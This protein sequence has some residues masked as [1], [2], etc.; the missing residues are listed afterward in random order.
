MS[1]IHDRLRKIIR[2]QDV[3]ISKF[4]REIEVGHGTI[5]CILRNESGVSNF[6]LEKIKKRYPQYNLC[7]LVAG[8]EDNKGKL[9]IDAIRKDINDTLD[10]RC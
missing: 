4:E 5:A 2:D 1:D 9:L 7:W 3:S 8:I 10:K 6:I